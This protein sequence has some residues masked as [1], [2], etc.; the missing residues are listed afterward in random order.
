MGSYARPEQASG[1]HMQNDASSLP[2]PS[3]WSV[4]TETP[5]QQQSPAM[6]AY[7][8][9]GLPGL[10]G[11]DLTQIGQV[12]LLVYL[13]LGHQGDRWSG[14]A[15]QGTGTGGPS[16]E[17]YFA[18]WNTLLKTP[19]CTLAEHVL[20]CPL[21][22][23]EMGWCI[24]RASRSRRQALRSIKAML[25]CLRMQCSQPAR[26]HCHST[27]SSRDFRSSPRCRRCPSPS[28]PR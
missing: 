5:G 11:L 27:C 3:P 2:S 25:G 7:Q 19:A 18:G 28:R 9:P 13:A 14:L 6:A 17:A 21:R 15:L 12:R 10:Q 1:S 23:D 26:V 16:P 4:Y 22:G 20:V 8:S 24:C